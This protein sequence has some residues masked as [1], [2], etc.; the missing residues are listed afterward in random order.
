MLAAFLRQPGNSPILHTFSQK[1]SV[2]PFLRASI[3][4]TALSR[5]GLLLLHAALLFVALSAL[6]LAA[7]SEG[8][9]AKQAKGM[10]APERPKSWFDEFRPA[11]VWD[12]LGGLYEFCP[13]V[14]ASNFTWPVPETSWKKDVVLPVDN[15]FKALN[16]AASYNLFRRSFTLSP[17]LKAKQAAGDRII[18]HLGGLAYRWQA[19]VNGHLLADSVD[20][21]NSHDFDVSGLLRADGPNEL[22]LG[23][24]SRNSLAYEN[25]TKAELTA[26]RPNNIILAPA[27]MKGIL[28]EDRPIN[29]V[30]GEIELW[31]RPKTE[32]KDVF[33]RC[34]VRKHELTVAAELSGAPASATLDA[35]VI[36]DA[37]KE[38]LRFPR[39]PVAIPAGGS[40]AS[41]KSTWENPIL[42]DTEN[43][44]MYS[45]EISL[46]DP[47]SGQQLDSRKAPFGFREIWIEGSDFML[48]GHRLFLARTS[49]HPNNERDAQRIINVVKSRKANSIRL[50][51]GDFYRPAAMAALADREGILL[52]PEA[53]FTFASGYRISDP[54]FWKNYH[55][56]ISGWIRGAR[57]HPSI[58]MWSLA[59]EILWGIR[60]NKQN[61]DAPRLLQETADFAKGIDPSR[62][63]QFDGDWDLPSGQG[64]TTPGTEEVVNL[65]YP[66]E[67]SIHWYPTECWRFLQAPFKGINGFDSMFR[68]PKGSKPVV[69]GEFSWCFPD[70]TEAPV[71]ITMYA[72]DRA[73]DWE[74][75]SKWT[76]WRQ[77][78][79]WQCDAWR[80]A[81][82]AG[83]NPWYHK[84]DNWKELMPLET[85]ALRS[86]A[87]SFFSKEDVSLEAFLLNDTPRKRSYIVRYALK[88]GEKALVE[89]QLAVS[90]LEAGGMSALKLPMTMPEAG[91]PRKLQLAIAVERDGQ[92]VDS[93]SYPV[94]IRPAAALAWPS[95]TALWD[96][97][98]KT[99]QL[100]RELGLNPV[101]AASP[102]RLAPGLKALVVGQDS[103]AQSTEGERAALHAFAQGGGTVLCL[104]QKSWPLEGFALQTL[105]AGKAN[106]AWVRAA[107]HPALKEIEDED[108]RLWRDDEWIADNGI[109]KPS[110]EQKAA[111]RSL[112][113]AGSKAGLVNTLLTE[114]F[115]GKGRY[116]LCQMRLDKA[117]RAP[118]ARALLANLLDDV[119]RKA[120]PRAEAS[121]ISQDGK[122]IK[123]LVDE[124]SIPCKSAWNSNS[125]QQT[126]IVEADSPDADP[127]AIAKWVEKGG[128]VWL[129]G[130]APENAA[131]W[132]A[133]IKGSFTLEPCNPPEGCLVKAEDPMLWGISSEELFWALGTWTERNNRSPGTNAK[134]SHNKGV[135]KTAEIASS[136]IKPGS[137]DAV[138]LV[139]PAALVKIPQG[140]GFWLLST[141]DFDAGSRAETVKTL[142]LVQNLCANL[143][144][145]PDPTK[146]MAYG[147]FGPVSLAKAANRGFQDDAPGNGKG[148]WG[149]QGDSDLRFFPVNLS[150]MDQ[151]GLP[152]SIPKEFPAKLTLANVEFEIIDPR[153]NDGKSCVMLEPSYGKL[154]QVAKGNYLEKVESLPVGRRFDRI[155]SLHSAILAQAEKGKPLWKYVLRYADGSSAELPVRLGIEVGDWYQ[156]KKLIGAKIAWRGPSMGI[157]NAPV[158]IYMAGFDNP[159]PEKE[160]KALDIVSCKEKGIP[161]IIAISTALKK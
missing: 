135:V 25:S 14:D 64:Y 69:I 147:S 105:E 134:D 139:D 72:G 121:I 88:D 119:N 108:L 81:R 116:L 32:I 94:R 159:H 42:W 19:R 123:R 120:E 16:P 41:L 52:I 92:T 149:D 46:V 99:S 71:P 113:D 144:L 40:K 61:S 157:K 114:V 161:G 131:K 151:A 140:K 127:A 17:A 49:G 33:V 117:N 107:G 76:V 150:G 7:A 110:E 138:K 20:A 87:L 155:Y 146:I 98:G 47:A 2:F 28:E 91:A 55:N 10:Q 106:F 39:T 12:D 125:L 74:F 124:L 75:W 86:H 118:G 84:D 62:P 142:R 77:L 103:L 58:V 31:A 148:G 54:R 30:W 112:I 70:Y 160:V 129:S 43:P 156:P 59:N 137:E 35:R 93:W 24:S 82:L 96:P 8:V 73:Y 13:L 23:T 111:W 153:K 126:L 78:M 53:P 48:N 65:H 3:A 22:V 132:A 9:P 50:H 122:A 11:A 51:F 90:A 115:A 80:V 141:I 45:L 37:G 6:P 60:F 18:L 83:V 145:A 56:M 57:N 128:R 44:Y 38:V 5:F 21:F 109:E 4:S 63:M 100:F 143:G 154:P 34:S 1:R 66:W 95:A 136:A 133:A 15:A 97:A 29:G 152:A 102:A 104:A 67:P 101:P 85:V 36:D 89:K 27:G 26:I 130:L 79:R 158:G 68:W